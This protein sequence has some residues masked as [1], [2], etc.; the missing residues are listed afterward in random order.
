MMHSYSRRRL[1]LAIALCAPLVSVAARADAQHKVKHVVLISVDGLHQADLNYY[2]GSHPNST[3]ARLVGE[4]A[5]YSN[6]RTP[7]PSDSF[8]GLTAQIT[9]GNPRSTGVYYDDS[10]NRALLAPG[11]TDCMHTA[12]GTEVTYFEA[13]DLNPLAIDAGTNVGDISSSAAIRSNIYKLSGHATDL[14]NPAMLPIDRTTC[15]VVYPHSYLRV[16]TVFEVA[17]AHGLHTAWSDKHAAYDL[18]N[19]PSGTGVDDL[20]APEINS[21]IPSGL[22]GDG[23]TDDDFTKDNLNTQFYDSLKVQAVLNWAAGGNHDGS[24]NTAGAPAIF[25]MNFQSVSTAQK[26]NLSHFLND[27]GTKGLGGYTHGGTLPGVVVQGALD[28]IDDSMQRII[29]AIDP[30]DTVVILSAKHGQSPLNRSLLRLIDDG[31]VT[32]ALDAAWNARMHASSGLVA[33]AIDDDGMLLWLKD[34]SEAASD[35]AADFLWHYQPLKVG[36]SNPDGTFR[37]LSGTVP[38]SGLRQIYA[39]EQAAEFIGV[40][41]RDSRVPD[42]IG[43]AAIGTVYSNPSKIKKISEHGG[44]AEQDRHVPIVVWGAGVERRGS[45]E[46]VETTQIAPTILKLLGLPPGELAAV[47]TEGTEVLPGLD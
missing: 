24:A 25:G 41:M 10:W 28:F 36:G 18:V 13:L 5:S 23:K 27:Q 29:S 39:G 3:L 44:N 45:N 21:T 1:A 6:S 15:K 17:K 46:R 42:V 40:P 33:F 12:P 26:L 8:P 43:I 47:R 22:V 16:N 14:I 35:F 32:A 19:G 20:F 38:H 7:F 4:G 31:E 37:D 2:V 34:R 9:G 11:S 30:R